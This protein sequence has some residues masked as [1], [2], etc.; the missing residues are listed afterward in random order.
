VLLLFD[1]Y[2]AGGGLGALRSRDLVGLS[3]VA[4]WEDVSSSVFADPVRHGSV[5]ELPEELFR[6]VA[7][8]A[9]R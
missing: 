5:I 2:A 7:L 3:D 4:S 6:A 9:A 8:S 1:K